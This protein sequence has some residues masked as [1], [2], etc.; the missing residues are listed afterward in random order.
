MAHR[1]TLYSQQ[2]QRYST[3]KCS[4]F[5]NELSRNFFLITRGRVRYFELT[6]FQLLS[7][8]KPAVDLDLVSFTDPAFMKD[9]GL[10]HFARNLG[11]VDLALPEIWRT[12]QIAD[13]VVRIALPKRTLESCDSMGLMILLMKCLVTPDCSRAGALYMQHSEL[14]LT[15]PSFQLQTPPT[16]VNIIITRLLL[17]SL[18]GG[19]EP[20]PYPS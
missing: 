15:Q 11:L 12:N 7:W 14:P 18:A 8:S 17:T 5:K 19:S 3:L 13:H 9:K 16:I 6:E 10:A 2:F 4:Y 1:S 20:D